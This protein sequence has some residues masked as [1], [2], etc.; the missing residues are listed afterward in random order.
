M[1]LTTH[2]YLMWSYTSIPPIC[3][4]GVDREKPTLSLN[5][6]HD[7]VSYVVLEAHGSIIH[8]IQKAMNLGVM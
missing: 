7:A 1:E 8:Q 5:V 6:Y 4:Q 2:L 3:L